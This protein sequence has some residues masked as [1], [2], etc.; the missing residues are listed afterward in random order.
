VITIRWTAAVLVAA[1]ATLLAQAPG[2]GMA[3]PLERL[4]M[5]A[6]F[7]IA[8]YAE[9]A[10]G[11]EMALGAKGTLFV[12]SMRGAVYAVIDA[13]KDHKADAV[14]TIATRLNQPSGLAFHNG[15]LFVVAVNRILRY[16]DIENKLDAP[17]P[18][19]VVFDKFPIDG[20][21]TWK[22]M[23]FGPD[24]LLYV[25]VGSPCN[26]CDRTKDESRFATI[27][28]MNPDGS[29]PEVF[30]NGVRNTVGFDW[31]PQTKALFFSD[32]GRDNLGDDMP[33]DE[34]NIATKPGMHFG[35]PFCHQGDTPDPEFGAN[36]QCAS[37]TAPALKVGSHVA[38]LGLRF[39]TGRMFPA[40]YRNA[41]IQAQH[42][43]WN[44]SEPQGYRVMAV[45]NDGSKVTG[46]EPLV[47]G[48]LSGIRGNRGTA[49]LGRTT[50]DAF[51]R[52]ADVL[53][54]PDGSVLIADDQG[55]RIF[56][57]SYGK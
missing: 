5:P 23:A 43:S 40:K 14:K 26:V 31:H 24:G 56:R 8:V 9:G 51:A 44:R 2:T 38:P 50:G 17:P 37:Y 4:K 20:G 1:S 22:F 35:F 42:G 55:G 33:S 52:P 25:S 15:S 19:V 34:L 46:Y 29:N 12:G 6:G 21:H 36:H 41:V 39:Y 54:M 57:L 16:D 30:A 27:M 13:N 47:D 28:R 32:N 11:R 7:K 49:P 53:V 45:F 48:F 18:P 10:G 3:L